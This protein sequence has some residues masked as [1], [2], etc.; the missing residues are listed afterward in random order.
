MLNHIKTPDLC[1]RCHYFVKECVRLYK[2]CDTCPMYTGT[3]E[4]WEC[5]CTSISKNTPCPYFI[6]VAEEEGG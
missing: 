2:D 1:L 4:H 3:D 5:K 6:E